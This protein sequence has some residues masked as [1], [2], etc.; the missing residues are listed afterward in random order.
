MCPAKVEPYSG[1]QSS[2]ASVFAHG[3]FSVWLCT[4]GTYAA[5]WSTEMEAELLV[6]LLTSW[7]VMLRSNPDSFNSVR[8]LGR[9]IDVLLDKAALYFRCQG[10]GVL[11]GTEGAFR[12]SI[13]C[14]DTAWSG[15]LE[16]EIGI[17]WYRIESS[18][19]SSSEQCLIATAEGDD[20][21]DQVFTSEVV[22]GSK[23]DF[24][25]D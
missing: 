17:V 4:H 15:H 8:G 24:Q 18:K 5:I 19:C 22:R 16:F 20:I 11:L 21:E 9:Q 13:D 3:I 1:P 7:T 12:V 10:C 25:C 23:D 2:Y 6:E 14:Y